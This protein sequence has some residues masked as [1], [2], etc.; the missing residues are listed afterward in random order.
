MVDTRRFYVRDTS[1][2]YSELLSAGKS[3][4]PL[5]L[6]DISSPYV[7]ANV[8][9][10]VSAFAV[11]GVNA[12]FY[13]YN[14]STVNVKLDPSLLVLTELRPRVRTNSGAFYILLSVRLGPYA[15]FSCNAARAARRGRLISLEA[16]KT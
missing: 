6:L 8:P 9:P 10:D 14:G 1:T 11:I 5:S 12:K 15:T 13:K 3:L 16:H 7:P 2:R 4:H